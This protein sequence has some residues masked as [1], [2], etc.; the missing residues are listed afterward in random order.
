MK[1]R[2]H[3]VINFM[4][5][6]I[7]DNYGDIHKVDLKEAHRLSKDEVFMWGEELSLADEISMYCGITAELVR[8]FTK[9]EWKK[10]YRAWRM[11]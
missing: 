6:G 11:V 8:T 1:N 7:V 2:I 3:F 10:V 4:A 5:E 9:S